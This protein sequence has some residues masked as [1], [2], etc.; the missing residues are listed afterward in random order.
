[1]SADNAPEATA[2]QSLKQGP[3]PEVGAHKIGAVERGQRVALAHQ[4]LAAIGTYL[5]EPERW[6]PPDTVSGR[7]KEIVFFRMWPGA[8][9][10]LILFSLWAA[11]F[12]KLDRLWATLMAISEAEQAHVARAVAFVVVAA[13]GV[14]MAVG[15]IV[16]HTNLK[17]VP[18]FT[19]GFLLLAWLSFAASLLS[20]G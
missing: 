1:M 7:V 17:P 18:R 14:S 9:G 2:T 11:K 12:V 10:N 3:S 6:V 4:V 20:S 19:L 13:V 16:A 15:A 8:L 5:V